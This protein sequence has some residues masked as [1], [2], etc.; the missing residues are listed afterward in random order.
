MRGFP[1]H[2]GVMMPPASRGPAALAARSSL[3][4]AR[5]QFSASQRHPPAWAHPSPRV[6]GG[7][8]SSS[9]SAGGGAHQGQARPRAA[10]FTLEWQG[11]EGMAGTGAPASGA[12]HDISSGCDAL[13]GAP[14]D[15]RRRVADRGSTDDFYWAATS[16]LTARPIRGS[17][18]QR[19]VMTATPFAPDRAGHKE[20][21]RELSV[22]TGHHAASR[23]RRRNRRVSPGLWVV[24]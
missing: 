3:L 15:G 24:S 4:P 21:R 1:R 12:E 20:G 2:T 18:L 14:G 16:G 5:D 8:R 9:R 19:R 6:Q 7:V 11:L 13:Q 23:E 17:G 22:D 10:P